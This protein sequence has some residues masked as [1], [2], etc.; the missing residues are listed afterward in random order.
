MPTNRPFFA[1][2]FAAFRAHSALQKSSPAINASSSTTTASSTA[3]AAAAAYGTLNRT[4]HTS[5]SPILP[6]PHNTT[7]STS[8]QLPIKQPP[9][10]YSTPH[11]SPTPHT[12]TAITSPPPQSHFR[13]SRPLHPP[14]G[15]PHSRGRMRSTSR[16]APVYGPQTREQTLASPPF[17]SR[18]PSPGG[19]PM[20][21]S[22]YAAPR[23]RRG[24]D[25]SSHS[26]GSGLGAGMYG[27]SPPAAP[28]QQPLVEKWYIGGRTAQ[29]EER[30]YKL[31]L[32]GSTRSADRLSLDRLSL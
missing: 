3:A 19:I 8:S 17:R 26:S 14:T 24:S 10:T 28:T 20:S 32:V 16:D 2:F 22:S 15:T 5:S 6:E 25:S 7:T 4:Y 9:T 27:A 21:S 13:S 1:N 12:T 29:G 23:G 11:H 31:G 30:F 18:T